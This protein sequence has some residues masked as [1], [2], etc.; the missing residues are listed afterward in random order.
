MSN[1]TNSG[2]N[3]F[4]RSGFVQSVVLVN[5]LIVTFTAFLIFNYFITEMTASQHRRVSSQ[6]GELLVSGISNLEDTMR[7]ITSIMVLSDSNDREGLVTQ[8]K[9]NVPNLGNFDQLL[10]LY[11]V[12]AGDWQYKVISDNRLRPGYRLVPDKEIIGRIINEKS[13]QDTGLHLISDLKGMSYVEENS[14]PK[15]MARSFAFV[16][17]I[18]SGD[19]S[20]GVLIGV[21]RAQMIFNKWILSENNI[22]SRLTIRD[23]K[24]KNPLYYMDRKV[25]K[26]QGQVYSYSLSALD[27]EWVVVMEL[28]KEQNTKLLGNIPYV[29]LLFGLILTAVGTLFLDGQTN[30]AATGYYARVAAGDVVYEPST[31]TIAQVESVDSNTQL[32][33]SAPGLGGGA[34]FDIYRGNGGLSNNKQGQE[35]FS[36]LVGTAG[37]LTVIPA[38]SENPVVLKNVANNSYVP[39]QVIRVFD[40]GT[41]ASDILA[42]Q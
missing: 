9:A 8:L 37:D 24:S 17:T 19:Y 41:T 7:L 23:S 31:G 11:E 34:A 27:S 40:S 28:F 16:K 39:L 18:K 15:I 14:N 32:T 20:K 13:F 42:L 3:L 10:W 35:G 5:G 1:K 26:K 6:A 25:D 33:L 22:V 21:S 30:P 38:A 12:S 4:H 2:K 36:L 29:V